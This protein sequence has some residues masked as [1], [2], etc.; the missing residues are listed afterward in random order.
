MEPISTVENGRVWKIWHCI[1]YLNGGFTF[2]VG[3]LIL[4]PIVSPLFDTAYASAWLYTI[5]SLTFL[6]AD[7]TE[8]LHYVDY[9]PT[10]ELSFNFLI[11]AIGSGLYLYGSICYIPSLD[12]AGF[13]SKLFIIGSSVI[14]FSQASKLYRMLVQKNKS[15]KECIE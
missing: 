11:S 9:S 13:G 8:W 15:Y 10:S 5:G 1:N 3:S 4:F 7:L 2:L 12:L 6:L 14:V